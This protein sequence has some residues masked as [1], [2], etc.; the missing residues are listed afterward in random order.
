M[1]APPPPHIGRHCDSSGLNLLGHPRK[2]RHMAMFMFIYSESKQ[3]KKTWYTM[4]HFH[5]HTHQL[6]IRPRKIP[7]TSLDHRSSKPTIP[8]TLPTKSPMENRSR[9]ERYSSVHNDVDESRL[10][11]RGELKLHNW[12]SHLPSA[13]AL[14]GKQG[15]N[16]KVSPHCTNETNLRWNNH[17]YMYITP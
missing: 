4:C 12:G 7:M 8:A 3:Q 10:Q 13:R 5:S 11:S 15:N 17:G 14:S 6:D 9:T 2:T 16:D 1:Y